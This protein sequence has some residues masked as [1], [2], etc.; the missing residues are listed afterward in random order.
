MCMPLHETACVPAGSHCST[1]PEAE[2]ATLES[3]GLDPLP[4]RRASTGRAQRRRS[5]IAAPRLSA[6]ERLREH[7]RKAVQVRMPKALQ[8]FLSNVAVDTLKVC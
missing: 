5:S 6:A 7:Q 8:S 1:Q 2:Q 3:E 4:S